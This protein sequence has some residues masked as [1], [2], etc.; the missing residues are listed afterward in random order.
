VRPFPEGT[1][2][3]ALNREFDRF[4]ETLQV[5]KTE[6]GAA[7]FARERKG[8]VLTDVEFDAVFKRVTAGLTDAQRAAWFTVAQTFEELPPS[9][10]A[11]A[12][13]QGSDGD[14]ISGVFHRGKV[15][16]VKDRFVTEKWLEEVILQW[17]GHAGLKGMFGRNSTRAMVELYNS[18]GGARMFTIGKKYGVNLMQY[19]Q[20]FARAGYDTDTIRALHTEEMLAHLKRLLQGAHRGKDQG[21]D[22]PDSR[23]AA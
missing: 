6:K 7:L 20:A 18:I 22:R 16:L 13:K 21:A 4:F 17:H 8:S 15:Y 10:K 1:E 19:G 9:I 2:R 11:E 12:Y 3:S 5:R 14:D 23:M